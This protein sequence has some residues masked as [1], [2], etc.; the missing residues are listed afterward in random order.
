[1]IVQTYHGFRQVAATILD[2]IVYQVTVLRHLGRLIDQRRVGRRIL[3]LQAFDGVNVTR[4]GHHNG[5]FFELFVLVATGAFVGHGV[6]C[7]L[8]ES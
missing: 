5:V 2:S 3:G 1:M 6:G 8:V 4:I 7:L